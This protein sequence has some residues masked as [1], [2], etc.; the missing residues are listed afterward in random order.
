[1]FRPTDPQVSLFESQF[2]VPPAK[3]ARLEQSWA[4]A[5]QAHVLPLIDEEVFRSAF[6]ADNGRPNKSIR[7]LVG[8]HLLKEWDDLTDAQVLD[9]LEFNLQWHYALGVEPGTAHVCQKTLHNFRCLLMD[10]DRAQQLFDSITRGLVQVDGLGV[11]RQRVDST[12]VVSNIALL[13]RLGL[14]VETIEAFFRQLR[15]S[16][17]EK[18]EGV[19][20]KYRERYLEREGYF[21][22]AKRGQVR[23]RLEA[24]A[25]DLYQLVRQFEGDG[26]VEE[27]AAYGCLV[28]LFEEQCE[29]ITPEAEV[30]V[31]P[32]GAI[33]VRVAGAGAEPV[34]EASAPTG[35][36]APE[37]VA[38]VPAAPSAA[39]V[40]AGAPEEPEQPPAPPPV[41]GPDGPVHVQ[42]KAPKE[43]SSQ[44]LQSPHDPDA[45]YGRKGKGYEVQVAETC[46]ADNPY[47][48]ITAVEVTGAHESDQQATVRVV[49]QLIE[50][51]LSPSELVADTGYG[52][53]DNLVACAE[54]GVVLRAPVQDPDAP[55]KAEPLEH[56]V[57]QV[58]VEGTEGP[59]EEA[60]ELSESGPLGLEDFDYNETFDEVMSCPLGHRPTQQHRDA[61]GK[62][63][64]AV[65]SAQTC[66]S[67][68]AA[69][70]CPTQPRKSGERTLR[71]RRAAA[72]T[73]HRQ[74]EQQTK[75]FKEA[76]KIRSGVES[77][78]AELKGR[79]GAGDLRIRGR[80]RVTLALQLKALALNTKRA[81]QH[82]VRRLCGALEPEPA[83]EAATG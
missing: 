80:S 62:T 59:D 79:H 75:A 45:T 70:R 55:R 82:H 15:R 18:L 71:S 72:A 69:G 30:A 23:R 57:E 20:A 3:R 14:F 38:D 10:N 40:A 64:W 27:L 67:C 83:L 13:T 44:S 58:R 34:G 42:L 35:P 1:M 43:I 78:N 81:V 11:G 37:R 5:F 76:Y 32:D 54:R 47:Q 48:V 56:P 77:T 49:E 61:S 33:P 31:E 60:E 50:R 28:R 25:A 9:N 51:G 19:G 63:T 26:A 41:P 68:P 24:V 53:G 73:A 21:A 2:L 46:E 36:T 17:P 4:H 22:D 74:R 12:H 16:C 39:A 65:F 52:S 6:H 8:V 29:V 7:L 66:A